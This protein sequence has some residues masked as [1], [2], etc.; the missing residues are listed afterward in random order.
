MKL[1]YISMP[2]SGKRRFLTKVVSKLTLPPK[3]RITI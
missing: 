3:R 2:E 1:A